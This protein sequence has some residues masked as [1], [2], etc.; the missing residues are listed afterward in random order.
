MQVYQN[1]RSASAPSHF[2]RKNPPFGAEVAV[3][4][5]ACFDWDCTLAVMECEVGTPRQNWVEC[6]GGE[7]RLRKIKNML[8]NL[9]QSGVCCYIVSRNVISNLQEALQALQLEGYFLEP[10]TGNL[11]VIARRH[12]AEPLYNKGTAMLHLLHSKFPNVHRCLFVD[13]D[14]QNLN[15]VQHAIQGRIQNCG[16][17]HCAKQGLTEE[18]CVRIV[19]WFEV[20][21]PIQA[22]LEAPK[23]VVHRQGA[24]MSPPLCQWSSRNTLPSRIGQQRVGLSPNFRARQ[25]GA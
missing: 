25:G 12:L 21:V 8:H 20:T 24:A 2:L 4:S 18:Q 13:D 15:D 16:S 14:A 3:Q 19:D 9:T 17:L 22:R 7:A 11:R 5:L 1:V 6:L 23:S 10:S